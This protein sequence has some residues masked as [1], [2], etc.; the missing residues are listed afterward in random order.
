MENINLITSNSLNN[1][2]TTRKDFSQYKN[3]GIAYSEK[4]G[5]FTFYHILGNNT[6][7]VIYKFAWLKKGVLHSTIP[8][9]ATDIGMHETTTDYDKN[10][11]YRILKRYEYSLNINNRLL[12]KFFSNR[13]PITEIDY[14]EEKENILNEV[15]LIELTDESSFFD[16]SENVFSENFKTF[17]DYHQYSM[18]I[19]Q[20]KYK[21]L[22]VGSVG[23]DKYS[24]VYLNIG[25]MEY[26]LIVDDINY[27]QNYDL[28]H[29]TKTELKA[30]NCYIILNTKIRYSEKT[31]QETLEDILEHFKNNTIETIISGIEMVKTKKKVKEQIP[32]YT[33]KEI[34]NVE[35]LI[36][37]FDMFETYGPYL[38]TIL[39]KIGSSNYPFQ[40]KK[41]I[42]F[43]KNTE[44]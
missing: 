28:I 44:L 2:E 41:Q 13:T 33:S 24:F 39:L 17:I 26:D 7:L 3:L 25:K 9:I 8:L 43:K 42:V 1:R 12:K 22:K 5:N 11:I 40:C 4:G 36:F 29:L 32:I 19:L 30:Y 27:N 23:I 31:I 20:K 15:E 38:K 16:S 34:D 18:S 10:K 14:L 35:S 21:T 6:T 37:N